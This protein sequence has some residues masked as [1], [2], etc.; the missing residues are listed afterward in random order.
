MKTLISTLFLMFALSLSAKQVTI[1]SNEI[2]EV[3]II[4][5][6]NVSSYCVV[7]KNGTKYE[8]YSR[9]QMESIVHLSFVRDSITFESK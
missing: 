4:S 5:S 1:K 6:N 9:A 7:L 3:L 2:K 8:L